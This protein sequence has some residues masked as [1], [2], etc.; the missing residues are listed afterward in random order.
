M[1]CQ[2]D[3]QV[4]SRTNRSS[5]CPLHPGTVATAEEV[6]EGRLTG[7]GTGPCQDVCEE[8]DEVGD[9]EEGPAQDEDPGGGGVEPGVLDGEQ[10]GGGDQPAGVQH[11]QL[12]VQLR[13]AVAGQAETQHCQ[14]EGDEE[15]EEVVQVL[16]LV[17]EVASWRLGRAGDVGE[18]W[19]EVVSVDDVDQLAGVADDNM[20]ASQD[21]L[22]VRALPVWDHLE[23]QLGD[24]VQQL[25]DSLCL[26]LVLELNLFIFTDD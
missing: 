11:G 2:A 21:L 3:T 7:A 23:G 14:A 17:Q 10:G 1:F 19:R 24:R 4:G 25:E 26:R 5:H 18:D 9:G 15:A 16:Q 12:P 13:P 8:A 22:Q 20:A 6:E